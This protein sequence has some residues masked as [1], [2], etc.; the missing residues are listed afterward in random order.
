MMPQIHQLD[1]ESIDAPLVFEKADHV[2]PEG[3]D[4]MLGRGDKEACAGVP[5]GVF[6]L[7]GRATDSGRM[8]SSSSNS[9]PVSHEWPLDF[10][11][12][13]SAPLL[14]PGTMENFHGEEESVVNEPWKN[15]PGQHGLVQFATIR[16]D[17][18]CNVCHRLVTRGDY[19]WG[20]RACDFDVCGRCHVIT[21]VVFQRHDFRIN[22]R[23]TSV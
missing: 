17:F 19:M 13:S 3:G 14:S 9:R 10:C 2:L 23:V 22:R 20:C 6:E 8:L 7:G 18:A 15:C 12:D 11:I 21:K 1:Y 4:H 5:V 16:S